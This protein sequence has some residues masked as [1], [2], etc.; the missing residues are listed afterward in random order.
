MKKIILL[1]TIIVA[2]IIGF[3]IMMHKEL[4]ANYIGNPGGE[5]GAYI[6]QVGTKQYQIKYVFMHGNSIYIVVP[7]D[8]AVSIKYVPNVINYSSG[9]TN[10]ATIKFE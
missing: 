3:G 9:K 7:I 6:L 2:L 4:S 8:S 10:T 1:V 5:K